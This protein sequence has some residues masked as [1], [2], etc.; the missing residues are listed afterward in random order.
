MKLRIL[1]LVISALLLAAHFLRSSSFLPVV[2][3][4]LVPFL[5]FIKKRWV[6]WVLQVFTVFAAVMWIIALKAI[7]QER[8]FEGRSWLASGIILGLVA[9]FTLGSGLWLNASRVKNSYPV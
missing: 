8:I 5:L 7:I 9:F 1:P 4:F 6:L 3:C 2:L